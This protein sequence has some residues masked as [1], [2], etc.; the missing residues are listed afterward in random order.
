[1]SLPPGSDLDRARVPLAAARGTYYEDPAGALAV[2]VRCYEIGAAAGDP[3]MCARA[4]ALQGM[5]SLHRG[6]LRGALGR[7]MEAERHAD[8]TPGAAAHAEVAALRAQLSFFTGSY[9]EA[10]HQA[11]RA[12]ER[13]DATHDLA[14]RLYA[15]RATCPVFGN[16]GVADLRRRVEELLELAIESSDAWEEAISRND[17]ACTL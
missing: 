4:S 14:L 10:L 6:D 3:E 7:A 13:A 9:T 16:V 17:L 8:A 11:E 12:V 15:R 1:M 2:A 5:V